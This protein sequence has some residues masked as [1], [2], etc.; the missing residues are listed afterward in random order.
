MGSSIL[1]A[2]LGGVAG[3]AEGISQVREQRRLEEERR[4]EAEERQ[5]MIERQTMLDQAAFAERGWTTPEARTAKLRGAAP[6]IQSVMESAASMLGGGPPKALNMPSLQQ[7]AGM[8]GAPSGEITIG[9][10]RLVLPET[11]TA[12]EERLA[13]KEA[14]ETRFAAEQQRRGA[15]TQAKLRADAID[16]ALSGAGVSAQ[17]RALVRSGAIKAEDAMPKTMDE[18]QRA[19]LGLSQARLGI[20]RER[21]ALDRATRAAG[22]TQPAVKTTEGERKAS[23]F[24]TQAEQA[25]KIIDEVV[26][27][28][29]TVPTMMER[30]GSALLGGAV[31]PY[32]SSKAYE[33]M[34]RAG[35]RLADAWLRFTSGAAVP[36]AEVRRQAMAFMPQPGED[37]QTLRDK[38][39]ARQLIIESLRQAAGRATPAPAAPSA[40]RRPPLSS[41]E[42]E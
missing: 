6:G 32:V 18:Y 10:R 15:E 23:A 8:Y 21:L 28:G 16:A 41:F 35:L 34:D 7:G 20:D 30:A 3:G 24:L 13:E 9:G 38:A 42:R 12:R 5:R 37:E 31:T 25:S 19:Q 4:R 36:E 14:G 11:S 27:G 40:G 29:K 33:R 2:I 26:A 1:Q 39:E 22:G 17:Q